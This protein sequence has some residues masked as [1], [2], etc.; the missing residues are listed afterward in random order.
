MLKG[1]SLVGEVLAQ[2]LIVRRDALRKKN[3]KRIHGKKEGECQR[4]QNHKGADHT[5]LHRECPRARATIKE[6]R[7]EAKHRAHVHLEQDT[8]KRH[9]G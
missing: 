3:E 4:R 9:R 2:R 7:G 6:K 8:P 1:R 5:K